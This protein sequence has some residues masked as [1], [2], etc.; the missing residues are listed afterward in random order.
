MT[1]LADGGFDHARGSEVAGGT[2]NC[3]PIGGGRYEGVAELHERR[4]A[5]EG[6]FGRREA[7]RDDCR[8]VVVDDVL[9]G[10]HHVREALHA[11]RLCGRGGHEQDVGAGGHRMCGLDIKRDLERPG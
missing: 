6:L 5:T 4:R 3:D 10:V 2:Q 8:E 11:E 7:L 9:L 1:A